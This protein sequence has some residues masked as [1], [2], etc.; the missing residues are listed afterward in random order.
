MQP[1]PTD[2]FWVIA[3]LPTLF[4][5][6]LEVDDAA[7]RRLARHVSPHVTGVLAGGTNA[8][9]MALTFDERVRLSALL[10]EELGVERVIVHI[11]DV[12]TWGARR[13]ARA[14][15]RDGAQHLAA[16]TPMIFEI[17][18]ESVVEHFTT[19]RAETPGSFYAYDYPE[20]SGNAL[21]PSAAEKL[22]G[23]VDGVK[24]SGTAAARITAIADVGL[25]VLSGDDRVPSA[26]HAAGAV[27]IVSGTASAIPGSYAPIARGDFSREQPLTDAVFEIGGSIA[28]IKRALH[29]AGI[30]RPHMR[31]GTTLLP[32]Q[33]MST[34]LEA[35]AG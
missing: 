28:G 13:L 17:G 23:V 33:A 8:E 19:L 1:R 15:V 10:I 25:P 24:L 18:D 20:I 3:A 11:G 21:L 16:L 29:G 30:G 14:V 5:D 27:G 9:F 31:V 22:V 35:P 7:M 26:V 4:D 6:D 2:T 34:P 12:T 32:R